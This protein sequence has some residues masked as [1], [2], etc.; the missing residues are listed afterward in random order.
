[1]VVAKADMDLCRRLRFAPAVQSPRMESN[2][3]QAGLTCLQCSPI[4]L[5]GHQSRPR[6][7][8][9]GVRYSELLPAPS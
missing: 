8:G 1:M 5:L 7:G 3:H 4:E 9:A 2:H 6:T